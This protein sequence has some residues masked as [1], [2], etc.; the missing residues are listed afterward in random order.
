MGDISD[1][2]LYFFRDW[3]MEK[4]TGTSNEIFVSIYDMIELINFS[5][6]FELPRLQEYCEKFILNISNKNL[7]DTIPIIMAYSLRHGLKDL[8]RKILFKFH[9]TNKKFF[10]SKNKIIDF[11]FNSNCICI[12]C[13]KIQITD[14]FLEN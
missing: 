6:I 7:E 2:S 5:K 9:S 14:I 13:R 3:C 12:E 8:Y 4:S 1:K 10:E 11:I